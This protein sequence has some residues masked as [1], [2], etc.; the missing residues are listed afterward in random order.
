MSDERVNSITTSIYNS[1]PE[2]KCYGTKAKV[3]LSGSYLKQDKATCNGTIVNIYIVYEI[4]KDYTI[5][6]YPTLENVLF[7]TVSLTKHVDIDPYRYSG[8]GTGF[9]RKSKFSWIWFSVMDLVEV[10]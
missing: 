6:S 10:A 9:D 8:Y 1:T 2:L 7:G 4:N 3:K 5:S